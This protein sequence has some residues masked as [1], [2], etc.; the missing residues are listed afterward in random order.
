MATTTPL[1]YRR[2]PSVVLC[3]IG[4]LVRAIFITADSRVIPGTIPIQ[5]V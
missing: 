1:S 3:S 5:K 2:Q 4:Y